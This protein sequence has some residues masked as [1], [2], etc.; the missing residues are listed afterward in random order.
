[1]HAV[2][3]RRAAYSRASALIARWL[4][5]PH[6]L[7]W[8]EDAR[9]GLHDQ[10][11]RMDMAGVNFMQLLKKGRRHKT[12]STPE[13]RSR[14][15]RNVSRRGDEYMRY[16]ERIRESGRQTPPAYSRDLEALLPYRR[17][18]KPVI[19]SVRTRRRFSCGDHAWR[20]SSHGSGGQYLRW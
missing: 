17:K 15:S 11:F 12:T 7:A 9:V 8:V 1:M 20:R 6:E 3:N 16:R 14:R 2:A 19:S 4:R 10:V 18:Q 13:E 5:T